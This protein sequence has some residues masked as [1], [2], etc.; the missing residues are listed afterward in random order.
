MNTLFNVDHEYTTEHW[1]D[2]ELIPI[3]HVKHIGIFSSVQAA[4]A[5]IA[6]IKHR[7]D[8]KIT[9]TAFQSMR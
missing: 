6:R 7:P 2:G 8:S 1:A 5:A 9:R 4:Q 3:D